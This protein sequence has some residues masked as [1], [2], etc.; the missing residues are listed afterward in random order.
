M[1]YRSVI[2]Y[3]RAA[4][5]EAPG[6]KRHGLNCIMRQ[7]H[8]GTREFSDADIAS[9]TVIRIWIGSMTGKKSMTDGVIPSQ[10]LSRLTSRMILSPIFCAF[11]MASR[12]LSTSPS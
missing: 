3:E 12:S 4:I 7:Y 11:F 9:V 10:L 5:L 8:G 1:R 6:E 2:G